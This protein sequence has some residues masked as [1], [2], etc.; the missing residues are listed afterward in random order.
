MTG[1]LF[2]TV[3]RPLSRD[4]LLCFLSE[5]LVTNWEAQELQYQPSGQ[6]KMSKMIYIIMS[7]WTRTPHSVVMF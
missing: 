3:G 4:V 6:W 7:E 2:Y 1:Q 5:V